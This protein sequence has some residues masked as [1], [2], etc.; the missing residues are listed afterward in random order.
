[1]PIPPKP[2]KIHCRHCGYKAVYNPNSNCLL[3]KPPSNKRCP[4]CLSWC[5]IS[6]AKAINAGGTWFVIEKQPFEQLG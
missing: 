2:L 1:M 6:D 4:Y 5:D 3:T